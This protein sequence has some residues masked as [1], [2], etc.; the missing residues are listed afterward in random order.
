MKK[1]IGI[2]LLF[3]ASV[4]FSQTQTGK[5]SFYADKFEGRPTA[6]GQ[7]FDQD[8]MTAAHR[9]LPFGFVCCI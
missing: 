7:K 1:L 8:K 6:N 5:A 3:L 9:T 2:A 4:G